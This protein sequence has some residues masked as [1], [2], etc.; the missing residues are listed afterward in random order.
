[1]KDAMDSFEKMMEKVAEEEQVNQ[2]EDGFEKML[3]AHRNDLLRKLKYKATKSNID[4]AKGFVDLTHEERENIANSIFRKGKQ[5][6]NLS[7]GIFVHGLMKFHNYESKLKF[8]LS[9][10]YQFGMKFYD[11]QQSIAFFDADFA[12]TLSI[13]SKEFN[14]KPLSHARDFINATLLNSGFESEDLCTVGKLKA[15]HDVQLENVL[16]RPNTNIS[17]RFHNFSEAKEAFYH[18]HQKGLRARFANPTTTYY[19][20]KFATVFE[21][22]IKNNF[23]GLDEIIEVPSNY[24]KVRLEQLQTKG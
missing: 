14:N 7:K 2:T 17:I 15:L 11:Q 20:A 6:K 8:L 22:A 24:A 21:N 10:P 13:N 3:R 18:M 12:N 23:E 19:D 9:Y 1:M 16:V 5:M 4:I